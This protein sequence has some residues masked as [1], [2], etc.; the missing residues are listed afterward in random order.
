MSTYID[1][2]TLQITEPPSLTST[3]VAHATALGAIP[4]PGTYAHKNWVNN[5]RRYQKSH[6]P[7]SRTI[8]YYVSNS[9]GNDSNDGLSMGAPF[10][11]LSKVQAVIDAVSSGNADMRF[12][13][14]RGD[15]WEE[16]TGLDL[17]EPHITL[18]AYGSGDKPLFN[19]FTVKYSES[20]WTDQSGGVYSISEANDIAWVRKVDDRL[21]A[22]IRNGDATLPSVPAGAGGYFYYDSVGNT[23]YVRLPSDANPGDSD[24]EAVIDNSSDS[25]VEVSDH[26]CR[27]VNIRADGWGC[28]D[29]TPANQNCG[30]RTTTSST[31]VTVFEGC[32]SY[33][34]SSHCIEHLRG[35]GSGGILLCDSCTVGYPIFNSGGGETLFNSYAET[36][37]NEFGVFD[38]SVPYG[39][40]PTSNWYT[41]ND[42]EVRGKL[43]YAHTTGASGDSNR[44]GLF[45]VYNL[46]ATHGNIFG[47]GSSSTCG[48][49]GRDG[50]AYN[51]KKAFIIS[52]RLT[53]TRPGFNPTE[54]IA[55]HNIVINCLYEVTLNDEARLS[56]SAGRSN[57]FGINTRWYIDVGSQDGA[58][59]A[60]HNATSSH[61][62]DLYYCDLIFH[63]PENASQDFRILDWD[64]SPANNSSSMAL[65]NCMIG[66]EGTF[67][68]Y[69]FVG[70]SDFNSCGYYQLGDGTGGGDSSP[71]VITDTA[72]LATAFVPSS[73]DDCFEAGEAPDITIEHDRLWNQRTGTPD[74]GDLAAAS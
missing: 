70:G 23:L 73:G 59:V 36:G 56:V 67:G 24:Y 14:K 2:G 63:S 12:R 69:S 61:V 20:S 31:E 7:I 51:Q 50:G 48:D 33:Y 21:T 55:L 4:D 19:R 62:G 49:G 16:T 43:C 22:F 5:W 37:G 40:L 47:P 15:V 9:T 17:D 30:F 72:E 8:T 28:S 34:T 11:T 58:T 54:L 46:D 66:I 39:T 53:Q 6:C 26:G 18:D 29:G 60:W 57:G 52:E 71:A 68:S 41:V 25:A 65:W 10:K 35:S 42:E 44:V 38:C 74:I 45:I 27:V 3:G 32:E 64:T 1:P 13:F